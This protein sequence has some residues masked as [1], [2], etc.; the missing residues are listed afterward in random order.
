[1]AAKLGDLTEY[2]RVIEQLRAEKREVRAR[3]QAHSTPTEISPGA[4]RARI[5]EWV[6]DLRAIFDP[7]L[8]RHAGGPGRPSGRMRSGASA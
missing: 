3:L 2:A 6:A 4:L 1:M 7:N 5:A 8:G